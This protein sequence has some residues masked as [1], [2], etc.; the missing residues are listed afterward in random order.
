MCVPAYGVAFERCLCCRAMDCKVAELRATTDLTR[1]W[2]HADLDAFFASVE[3]LDD[4]SLV[5][6]PFSEP[7]GGLYSS[8]MAGKGTL[9]CSMERPCPWR[10]HTRAPATHHSALETAVVARGLRRSIAELSVCAENQA[11]GRGWLGNHH[12]CQL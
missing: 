1:I 9:L 7:S 2:I 4:P 6:Q 8:A 11:N 5:R 12:H 3:E 10:C